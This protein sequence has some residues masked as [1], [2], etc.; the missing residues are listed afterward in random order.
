MAVDGVQP[1]PS[2]GPEPGPQPAGP[3]LAA[4]DADSLAR[5]RRGAGA[6]CLAAGMLLLIFG[7]LDRTR[8][9]GAT[10]ALLF[11]RGAGA[12]ALGLLLALLRTRLGA[13]H[14]RALGVVAAATT[15]AIEQVLALAAEGGVQGAESPINLGTTFAMLGAAVLI[16]WSPV[17]SAFACVLVVGEYVGT[18]VGTGRAAG[19]LFDDKLTLFVAVGV[20]AV[21]ISAVLQRRR[22]REFL[23]TWALAAAHREAREREKRY[24]S[25]VETAGSI[26]VVLAPQGSVTEFNREAER[27]LGWSQAAA[28][29]RDFL[30][31][32]VTQA[33]RATVAADIRMALAGEPTRAFEARLLARDGSERV[34]ACGTTRLVDDAGRAVGVLLCAQDISER[35][36]VEEALRESEARLRAVID[37][38]PVVLFA[39]DRTGTLT[40]SRGKGLARLGLE[41]GQRVGEPIGDLLTQT[42][43][44]AKVY[45]DRA[46]AGEPV[47]WTG[48]LG[49]ATFECRLMPVADGRSGPAG[50]IGLAIDVTERK[51]AED[52]RLALERRLLE[53]QKLESLGVLAGGIAH[54]FNNL[55]VSVL[56]NASLALG[57]LPSHAPASEALRRIERA[58][59]RGSELTREMLAYAGKHM[60]AL[61]RVDVNALVAETSDLLSVSIGSKV[62][63]AYDLAPGLPAIEA[64]PIQIRQVIMNL[65]INASEAIGGAEGTITVCT[66]VVG[67]GPE[68]LRDTLHPPEAAPGPHV[69]VEVRDTGC[70]MDAATVAKVFDPFF[71]TKLTV[72]GLGL[73]TVLGVVRRHRGALAITSAP[74]RGTTFRV[75]LPAAGAA[76]RLEPPAAAAAPAPGEGRE[77]R[78]VLLVDDEEDVRAVTAHM[79]ERLGCSVLQAGD[80][81]EGVDVFRAHARR[82]DAV[83]VDLTLPRL[84]GDRVFREIRSIRPDACVILMSGYSDE[85]ATGGLAEAGLAGFLRKPFSVADLEKALG[86]AARAA[87]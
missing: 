21:V 10:G 33:S 35:K 63:M 23:Q 3:P 6:Y 36:R 5:C 22:W 84:S 31:S 50:I 14:P 11:V 49:D 19:L 15:G 46:F 17:W 4:Y 59:R 58:A 20:V 87:E 76:A 9:P 18:A 65:V 83:I 24:R 13:R 27:V 52:A 73:A 34:M 45:F 25:V 44:P 32:F 67:L 78:T 82:I 43:A 51:Q 12:A 37:E 39:L 53:A 75:Y 30:P 16:P 56:G 66:G 47:A 79:L 72:R 77:E 54:D 41:P 2:P 29:G 61:E 8:F 70:G 62:A 64:D 40:F 69:C 1:T 74:G 48:S 85:R 38:A 71:S 68:A 55:L 86:D 81:R 80:G 57:E 26:I 60:I 28:V 7:A 42:F